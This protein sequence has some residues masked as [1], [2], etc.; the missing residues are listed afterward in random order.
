MQSALIAAEVAVEVQEWPA[1]KR[2]FHPEMLAGCPRA[3]AADWQAVAPDERK[4]RR[5]EDLRRWRA[6]RDFQKFLRS[7]L[8]PE[9][10]VVFGALFFKTL[11]FLAERHGY[12]DKSHKALHI[13][14]FRRFLMRRP[15]FRLY[16]CP[17]L[18]SF[19]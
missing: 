2:S 18:V 1:G 16:S 11:Y 7:P 14:T 15:L 3:T 6:R 19:P 9:R 5:L 13:L 17:L 10:E 8:L 4:R 12:T